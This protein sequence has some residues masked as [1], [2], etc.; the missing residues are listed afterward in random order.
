LFDEEESSPDP[1]SVPGTPHWHPYIPSWEE[2]ETIPD[3]RP[4]SGILPWDEEETL[5]E[6]T[7]LDN[8]Q[9]LGRD[10]EEVGRCRH[11]A[12]VAS[13]KMPVSRD[14]VQVITCMHIM[15]EIED[16]IQKSTPAQNWIYDPKPL[17]QRLK[18]LNEHWA[19]SLVNQVQRWLRPFPI[20]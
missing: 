18:L 13:N 4:N 9:Q 2:E 5:G 10:S 15:L 11:Q 16:L 6:N 19:M 17:A 3:P 1:H 8:E 14:W 20:P 7:S 12:N